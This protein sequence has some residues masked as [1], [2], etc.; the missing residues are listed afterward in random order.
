MVIDIM[1]F[2]VVAHVVVDRRTR[3]GHYRKTM[4]GNYRISI[5]MPEANSMTELVDSGPHSPG[6]SSGV[7]VVATVRGIVPPS[8]RS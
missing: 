7:N 8:Q 6:I 4:V 3:A 5:R 1:L 2:W